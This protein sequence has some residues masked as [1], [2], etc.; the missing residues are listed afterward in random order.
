MFHDSGAARRADKA[1]FVREGS[2]KASRE[3][4]HVRYTTDVEAA[5]SD[6]TAVILLS[7]EL[8]RNYY[9]KHVVLFEEN[10]ILPLPERLESC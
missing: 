6:T 3:G 9:M 5:W 8:E 4:M 7:F 10:S 1:E 2:E